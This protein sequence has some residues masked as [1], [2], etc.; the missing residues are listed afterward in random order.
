MRKIMQNTVKIFFSL[1][2]ACFIASCK[3]PA[4]QPTFAVCRGIADFPAI[5]TAG[6]DYVE[7]SVGNFL[8]PG[9]NDSVFQAN[10]KQM[11]ELGAKVISCTSFIPGNLKITGTETRHDE[12]LVWAETAL[13]R[14][15]MVNMPYIVLGSGGARKIPDGFDKQEATRQFTDLCK[16]LAPLAEKYNVTVVIEP[17][18]RGETNFINSLSEGA[19]IVKEVNH[20]NIRL[21]CDIY[22]MM[23]E[24]EPAEE[25]VKYGE[26]LRHCHIAEKET[27]SA[28]GTAG[29][30]F[31]PYFNALK[32]IKYQ[33]CIS[34]EGKWDDFEKRLAPALQYMKEQYN[35]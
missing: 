25:I 15:Q 4:C 30:D 29:D 34:I 26:L 33:G 24:D 14:A 8:V 11:D 21:L 20:P 31:K 3:P 5:A 7:T 9:Q 35:Q 13:R 28:P 18:N 32:K 17:L 27:R 19:A 2:I 16:K 1:L 10:M 6:Y 22:H 12:I 23:R